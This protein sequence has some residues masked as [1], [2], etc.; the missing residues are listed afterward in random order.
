MHATCPT[1]GHSRL[2][3][4][5]LSSGARVSAADFEATCRAVRSGQRGDGGAPAPLI[6]R[7]RARWLA[8]LARDELAA[9]IAFG[10]RRFCGVR[11]D[12][13]FPAAR[14]AGTRGRVALFRLW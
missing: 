14:L 5:H 12:A 8:L 1:C 7:Y 13:L 11:L 4:Y 3:L 2:F 6:E 10:G 9:R